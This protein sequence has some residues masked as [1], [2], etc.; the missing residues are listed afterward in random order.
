M[1]DPGDALPDGR[2]LLRLHHAGLEH[3]L[4]AHLPVHFHAPQFS[5][6]F[7]DNRAC[8]PLNH[9]RKRPFHGQFLAHP[10][11]GAFR[12]GFP[13]CR[14]L[15]GLPGILRRAAYQVLEALQGGAVVRAETQDLKESRI[16]RANAIVFVEDNNP[17]IQP[18]QHLLEFRLHF[19]DLPRARPIRPPSPGIWSN[20][21]RSEIAV[22][23]NR[24]SVP[25]FRHATS[26]SS[27]PWVPSTTAD[28]TQPWTSSHSRGRKTSAKRKS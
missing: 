6:V 25:F 26:E 7:P 27:G 9:L 21:S 19:I 17:F 14:E 11:S 22:R 16:L 5:P 28:S 13:A 2:Q 24:N 8:G 12:K 20:A 4:C 15:F 18:L 23:R 3:S 10:L 1:D